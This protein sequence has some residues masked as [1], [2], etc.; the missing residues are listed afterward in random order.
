MGGKQELNR[1]NK[2]P[3]TALGYK[4]LY[5]YLLKLYGYID[6]ASDNPRLIG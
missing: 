2:E 6:G 1:D 3:F 4:A 5:C